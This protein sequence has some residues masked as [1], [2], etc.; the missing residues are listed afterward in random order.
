MLPMGTCSGKRTGSLMRKQ[1]KRQLEVKPFGPPGP[2]DWAPPD[3]FYWAEP[4]TPKGSR[5][6]PPRYHRPEEPTPVRRRRTGRWLVGGI[7]VLFIG[8]GIASMVNEEESDVGVSVQVD[9]AAKTPTPSSEVAPAADGP[10]RRAGSTDDVSTRDLNGD[11]ECAAEGMGLVSG[12]GTLTNRGNETA[13]YF[14][15][16]TFHGPDHVR[17]AESTAM[18][19]NLRVGETV[20]WAATG[21]ARSLPDGW[22]CE[23]RDVDR[24]DW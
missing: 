6:E 18:S 20:A 24:W 7:A 2:R 8:S 12:R 22:Y 11:I 9:H 21:F 1:R 14:I 5:A 17:F 13:S 23:V 3:P 19:S 15:S 16:V 10:T 4:D